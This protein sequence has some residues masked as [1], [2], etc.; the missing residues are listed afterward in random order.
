MLNKLDIDFQPLAAHENTRVQFSDET[1]G[2]NI[3]KQFVPHVE[4]GFRLACEKGW[5][6]G[7]KVAGVRFRLVDGA[8]HIVDSNEISFILAAQGAMRQSKNGSPVLRILF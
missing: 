3:P 5:L 8:S 6:T 2:T 1:V 4:K 7:H